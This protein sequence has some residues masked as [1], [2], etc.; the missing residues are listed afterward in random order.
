MLCTLYFLQKIAF[1]QLS[2]FTLVNYD[3]QELLRPLL[4]KRMVF[5][6]ILKVVYS[7]V[8]INHEVKQNLFLEF[9]FQKP[10]F[11]MQVDVIVYFITNAHPV[12]LS[13][14]EIINFFVA[15]LISKLTVQVKHHL[16]SAY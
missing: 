7:K 2:D 16:N 8:E 1:N 15:G 14:R 5:L 4:L 9:V 12:Q 3:G 6:L 11:A 10:C 13:Q